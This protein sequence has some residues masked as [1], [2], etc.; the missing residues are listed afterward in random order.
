MSTTSSSIHDLMVYPLLYVATPYSK[1]PGG[2][3]E[4][5]KDAASIT[6]RLIKAGL[7]VYSP[8]VH[9]HPCALYGKIDPH[10]HDIWL[11]YNATM[12]DKSEA[13]LV[14]KMFTWESSVGIAHEIEWFNNARKPV[15][16]LDPIVLPKHD[17]IDQ[18]ND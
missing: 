8:I 12:M 10:N 2:L 14:I 4:A 16:Y 3:D 6:G 9:S 13:L 15:H 18:G 7:N 11:P 17:P 5:F 1:Y